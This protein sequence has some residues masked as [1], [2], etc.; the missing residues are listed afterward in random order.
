MKKLLFTAFLICLFISLLLIGASATEYQYHGLYNVG[1]NDVSNAALSDYYYWYATSG[2]FYFTNSLNGDVYAPTYDAS[3]GFYA[4]EV[5]QIYNDVTNARSKLVFHCPSFTG[6]SY[7]FVYKTNY[8]NNS[9]NLVNGTEFSLP[10]D[11]SQTAGWCLISNANLTQHPPLGSLPQVNISVTCRTQSV[12]LRSYSTQVANSNN[13][14]PITLPGI[15]GY[16]SS[17]GYNV[18]LTAAQIQSGAVVFY[19]DSVDNIRSSAYS[20]GQSAGD[21]VGYQRAYTEYY[22]S[23]YDAGYAAARQQFEGTGSNS[24]LPNFLDY[25]LAPVASFLNIELY[26]DVT[27]GFALMIVIA[28]SVIIWL[29]KMFFGG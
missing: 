19:Y 15:D 29:V 21:T 12:I 25:T 14:Q 16:V 4:W 17:S 28:L 2:D 13:P 23:R 18:Y 1:S 5:T 22:Q 20:S 24:V 9:I 26:E 8:F 3:N 11:F 7:T 10:V 6:A 27:L